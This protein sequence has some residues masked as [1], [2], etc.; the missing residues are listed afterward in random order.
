MSHI[1]YIGIGTNLGDRRDNYK[2][3][4]EHLRELPETKVVSQ[5]SVYESEPHGRARNWFLN[6]VVG[7][8]TELDAKALL[9]KL[10]KIEKGM[11]RKPSSGKGSVSR[12]MD[13]DILLFDT[14]VIDSRTL[15]V[16]HPEIPNRRF[17]L[18]PLSELAPAYKHPQSGETVS[19]MLVATE[20]ATKVVLYRP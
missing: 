1:A 11:G 13:L 17:V 18:L 19:S 15:K 10:Q 9:K 6:G 5:S 12:V 8:D 14:E 3:A 16:P 4:I 2:K 20:D 7:I